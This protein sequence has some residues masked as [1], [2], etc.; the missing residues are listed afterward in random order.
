MVLLLIRHGKTAGNLERRYVGTTDESLCPKG[1]RELKKRVYPSVD[2]VIASPM[3]RCVETARILFGIDVL[4][5]ICGGLRE[6]DFGVFEYHNY[7]ELNGDPM[8]Q[9]WIDSG[10]TMAIPKGESREI[11]SRRCVR[12]FEEQVDQLIREKSADCRAA[13]VV[14]GGTIMAVME[15]FGIPRKAYYDWQIKNGQALLL[16]MDPAEWI[17]GK[18]EL[19]VVDRIV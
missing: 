9:A 2:C 18:K 3:K 16:K 4:V 5:R 12:A 13:F 19:T 17:H 15:Q 10:G 14:H 6:M 1:I 11:F 7:E 8:Y